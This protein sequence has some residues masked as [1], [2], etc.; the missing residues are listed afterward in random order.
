MINHVQI[1]QLIVAYTLVGAFVFTVAITCMSLIGWI[2]FANKKQQQKLFATLI[3]QLVIV[4]VGFFTRI[5]QFNPKTVASELVEQGKAIRQIQDA[6]Q[7]RHFTD[8]QK[9]NLTD[10]L[11][12]I[13]KCPIDVYAM[14]GD[15]EAI[16]FSREIYQIFKDAGWP[17]SD[18]KQSMLI[19]GTPSGLFIVQK[20]WDA[21]NGIYIKYIFGL[22]KFDVALNERR[23]MATNIVEFWVGTRP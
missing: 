23:D 20:P 16:H 17:I 18:L 2:K 22:Q 5:L 3:I 11:S 6:I 14:D 21:T 12:K 1:I 15:R 8:S 4:C 13:S 19:G 10:L 7:E 9:T